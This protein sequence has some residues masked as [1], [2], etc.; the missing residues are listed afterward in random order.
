MTQGAAQPAN[1]EPPPPRSPASPAGEPF[2]YL[3]GDWLG[4]RA[5][6]AEKGL[7]FDIS[8]TADYTKNLRG[9]LD[10]GGSTVRRLLEASVKVDTKPLLG[11]E[12]GTFFSSFQN[13]VG[14]NPSDELVGDLQGIDGLDGVPGTRHQNR[15]QLSQLWYQQIVLDG[16]FRLK[17]GKVD[18]NTE[19]DHSDIAQNFLHQSTGSSATLF[20]LPT[21]P[22]PATG[23]NLFVKPNK[24]LQLGFGIY[25][26]SLGYGVRTGELGPRTLLRNSR[27]L[28]LIAE[29]DQ[30]WMLGASR[31]PGRFA[32]GSG[33][34]TNDFH[35]LKGGKVA[36]S[37][38]PYLLLDQALW[39]ANP[40]DD[41]DPRG[42]DLFIMYGYADPAIIA[43][44][45]NLG[46]G[47]AWTGPFESRPDDIAGAG[48]QAIYFSDGYHPRSE[49]EVSYEI[50]YRLQ[51]VPGFALKPDLQYISHPGGRGTPDALA[52]T[53]RLE[54]HL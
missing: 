36:G 43:Y 16:A 51:I 12:G 50:F 2:P 3:T 18:A 30:S 38:T 49:T 20:T 14:P 48:I 54:V 32:I 17:L 24:D 9:G 29:A 11:L 19:F 34:S 23:I 46:G 47:V 22:D 31:L 6:L 28:F 52:L 27:D 44:D 13:A 45:H 25:D 35:R 26:G 33:Y 39:R 21:Y 1:Q 40:R 5:A 15:T 42:I 8:Y 10:T 53:I 7:T 4:A 37:A 41:H